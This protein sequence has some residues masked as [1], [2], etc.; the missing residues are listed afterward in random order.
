M[1][2][3]EALSSDVPRTQAQELFLVICLGWQ[4]ARAQSGTDY[5]PHLIT[6]KNDAPLTED[7]A[8]Y[9]VIRSSD[10]SFMTITGNLYF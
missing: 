7:Q 8:V 1:Q 2:W 4:L 6:L 3:Q 5:V 10:R 9:L